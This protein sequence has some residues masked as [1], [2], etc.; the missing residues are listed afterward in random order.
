[1]RNGKAEYFTGDGRPLKKSF[2]R[3]PIPYARLTSGFGARRHPVLG[4]MRMHKG[5]DY[6]AGTGTPIMAAGDARVVSA[7]WQGGYGNAVVLDHGRGYTTLYGH[8]SRVGKIK[9]GQRIAQGTVIGYVGS[10]GMSTGPHLHYEFRING[11]HR[12]PLSITMPP[13]EP[14]SGVALAQFR[15][16]TSVALARIREVENIIYADAGTAPKPHVASTTAKK[17]ARKG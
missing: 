6:A 16:Q 4:R 1:M 15:Q 3:M 17:N 2:I 12:N 14:L 5:V 13:P 10:T 7:G 8:M 11:V 9:R